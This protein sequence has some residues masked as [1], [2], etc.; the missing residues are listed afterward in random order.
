MLPVLLRIA[1]FALFLPNISWRKLRTAIELFLSSA[2]GISKIRMKHR[3]AARFLPKLLTGIALSLSPTWAVT[4][5]DT[6]TPGYV[7]GNSAQ[8]ATVRIFFTTPSN[9]NTSCSG[10]LI[11]ASVVLTA[12]HCVANNTNFSVQFETASGTNSVGVTGTALHPLFAN[13]LN[14]ATQAYDVA[15]I[16]LNNVAPLDAALYSINFAGTGLTYGSSQVV[17]VG[18]GR[19]GNPTEGLLSSGTRRQATNVVDTFANSLNGEAT[20]DNPL[21]LTHT[22]GSGPAGDGL[23]TFGDSGGALLLNGQLI[24][25]ASF[26]TIPA[27]FSQLVNGSVQTAG[28]TNLTNQQVATW[29]ASAAD[30]PEPSTYLL[31]ASGLGLLFLRK[32]R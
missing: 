8:T 29:L 17:Q 12:G 19:G 3:L 2:E 31:F 6:T 24:G 10:S 32:R 7:T 9:F 13:R 15:V 16:Y 18:Y 23:V 25:V 14:S 28:F 5:N 4:I 26:S 27:D 20:P 1:P 30:I 11:R 21:V 22:F